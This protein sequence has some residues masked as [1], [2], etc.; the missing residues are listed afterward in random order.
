MCKCKDVK[1]GSY[2]NQTILDTPRCILNKYSNY[3]KTIGIDNCILDEIRFLWSN[4]II[5][6]G[7][8]CG[9]NIVNS[10]VNVDDA[11]ISKMKELGYSVAYNS[12]Y[13]NSEFTFELK[14]C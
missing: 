4:D 2:K 12:C 6:L 7:S 3:P 10:M 9:H 1:M 14:S 11:C 13:P 5:T 8:C